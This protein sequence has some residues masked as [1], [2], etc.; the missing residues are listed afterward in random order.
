MSISDDIQKWLA[1][2]AES[3]TTIS[4]LYSAGKITEAT[5]NAIKS[6]LD[7]ISSKIGDLEEGEG[8]IGDAEAVAEISAEVSEVT[9]EI[10]A[11]VA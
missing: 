6:K 4:G 8:I 10:A 9:A 3:A 1:W 5:Y 11:A 7:S 2:V